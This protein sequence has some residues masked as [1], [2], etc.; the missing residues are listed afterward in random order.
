M[1][2]LLRQLAYF[3]AVGG[4]ASATHWLTTVVCI[5]AFDVLPYL[6]NFFGWSVAVL[7]SF[8]GHYFLTFRYQTKS[9]G[10]AIRRFFTVSLGGFVINELA[11]VYLLDSSGIAY[12][13]L[14]AIILV[15]VAVLTFVLSRYWAFQHR[16]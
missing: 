12:Y 1:K 7:V 2:P 14:L 10:P 3:V 6:A 15:A 4:A 11:F 16:S 8:C 9:L 5:A 13:W